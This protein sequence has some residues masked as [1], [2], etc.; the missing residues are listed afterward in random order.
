MALTKP[1]SVARDPVQ[2]AKWDELTGSRKFQP[3]DVPA[4]SLLC[5]WYAIVD[6]CMDDLQYSDGLHV[7]YANDLSD[8]KAFPQINTIKQA[9]AEIRQLNRQLGIYDGSDG[10]KEADDGADILKLIIGK[11]AEEDGLAGAE[12]TGRAAL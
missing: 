2:S 4:L 12:D 3:H 1:S 6:K 10:Q 5:M 9:S 7:A 11:S 8:I